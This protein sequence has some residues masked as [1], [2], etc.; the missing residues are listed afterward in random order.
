MLVERSPFPRARDAYVTGPAPQAV[1]H[2]CSDDDERLRGSLDLGLHR[3]KTVGFERG[4]DDV[5]LHAADASPQTATPASSSSVSLSSPLAASSAPA[6]ELFDAAVL[7]GAGTH[8]DRLRAADSDPGRGQ[9]L[10]G[11]DSTRREAPPPARSAF[12]P[13]SRTR[14]IFLLAHASLD[15]GDGRRRLW[16]RLRLEQAKLV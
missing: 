3:R 6:D 11:V 2:I 12:T 15:V 4:A 9:S 1:V 8:S 10:A 7:K 13:L 5:P 16:H 14:S